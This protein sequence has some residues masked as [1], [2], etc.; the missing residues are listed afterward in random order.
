MCDVTCSRG[1]G[2]KYS[3]G[4]WQFTFWLCWGQVRGRFRLVRI[5]FVKPLP[6][7]LAGIRGSIENY[8]LTSIS[9]FIVSRHEFAIPYN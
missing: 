6:Q 1:R 4:N 8:S 2:V 5:M 7:A 9:A 3:C